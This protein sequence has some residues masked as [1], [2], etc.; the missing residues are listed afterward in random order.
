QAA[1][2]R[3]ADDGGVVRVACGAMHEMNTRKSVDVLQPLGQSGGLRLPAALLHIAE[4]IQLLVRRLA[5]PQYSRRLADAG[6]ESAAKLRRLQLAD[7]LPRLIEMRRRLRSKQLGA[8]RYGEDLCRRM[9]RQ[10]AEHGQG[11]GLRS[12]EACQAP[13]RCGEL[14]ER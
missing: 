12:V 1:L 7:K 5:A 10:A 4:K 6:Q 11:G 9:H 14:F 8:I 2:R 13:I 3:D